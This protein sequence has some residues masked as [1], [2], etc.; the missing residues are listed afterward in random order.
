MDAH[1]ASQIYPWDVAAGLLMIAEAGGV[2]TAHNGGP[3]NLAKANF[4]A[5]STAALHRDL[6]QTLSPGNKMKRRERTATAGST[7]SLARMGR[8]NAFGQLLCW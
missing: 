4:L 1:W 3:F 8:W 2:V 6:L 5:A 7:F